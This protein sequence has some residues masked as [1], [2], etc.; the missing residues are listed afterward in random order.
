METS[1][2]DSRHLSEEGVIG[3]FEASVRSQ[4]PVGRG[5]L[6]LW[7][8]VIMWQ[9]EG[10]IADKQQDYEE[11][12]SALKGTAR[13]KPLICQPWRK[14][15]GADSRRLKKKAFRI[16][17]R[18]VKRILK[19]GGRKAGSPLFLLGISVICPHF[20][21]AFCLRFSRV[22]SLAWQQVREGL[23]GVPGCTQVP[24]RN[25]FALHHL[26]DPE[27]PEA[28]APSYN[29]K[30][31]QSI[32]DTLSAFAIYCIFYFLPFWFKSGCCP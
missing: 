18:N 25:L 14:L 4:C 2:A 30:T 8:V 31:S 11:G 21:D 12:S 17:K 27:S 7:V 20:P 23:P 16:L 19:Q 15:V 10:L 1:D 26:A 28:K 22:I 32:T 13:G 24:V 9:L 3:T 29:F 6:C 5:F